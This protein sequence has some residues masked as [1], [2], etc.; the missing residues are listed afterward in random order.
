MSRAR[1]RRRTGG[2]G[3][4]E[5]QC[6]MRVEERAKWR[7]GKL[8][9]ILD[10]Q[11]RVGEA[12]TGASH[13]GCEVAAGQSSGRG[14]ATWS[15]Q[16]KARGEKL[17]RRPAWGRRVG[18]D[19]VGGGASRAAATVSGGGLRRQRGSSVGRRGALGEGH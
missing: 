2:D 4:F 18:A 1:R 12:R 8:L 17:G 15:A 7:E 9:S 6:G 3:G 14:G 11:R 16:E 10:Q 5:T 13:D 19:R